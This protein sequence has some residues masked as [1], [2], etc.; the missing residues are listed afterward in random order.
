M[1]DG[2]ICLGS[3]YI[4][5]ILV[6]INPPDHFILIRFDIKWK[7]WMITD[8][9]KVLPGF[10]DYRFKI[11]SFLLPET[12]GTVI[13]IFLMLIDKKNFL[14]WE[15]TRVDEANED[16]EGGTSWAK[17]DYIVRSWV[18]QIERLNPRLKPWVVRREAASC[19]KAKALGWFSDR[20]LL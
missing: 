15:F 2:N 12:P 6:K 3:N 9:L 16:A 13:F 8:E 18:G 19:P 5:T 4:K 17:E 14:I 20:P 7:A 1:W 11:S 10:M